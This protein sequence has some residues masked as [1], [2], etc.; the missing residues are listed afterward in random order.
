SDLGIAGGGPAPPACPALRAASPGDRSSGEALRGTAAAAHRGMA[1]RSRAAGAERSHRPCTLCTGGRPGR[2]IR[3][4]PFLRLPARPAWGT[5]RG[6]VASATPSAGPA[7][8]GKLEA[9]LRGGRLLPRPA[10]CALLASCPSAAP[11]A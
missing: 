11:F 6:S 4:P 1:G 3:S 8:E 10:F 7:P 9:G 2:P 5:A